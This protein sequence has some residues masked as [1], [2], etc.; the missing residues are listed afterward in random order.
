MELKELE[1]FKHH[2][3]VKGNNLLS[4]RGTC[5]CVGMNFSEVESVHGTIRYEWE[6]Y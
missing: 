3:R 4:R 1:R 2:F 6:E 5:V